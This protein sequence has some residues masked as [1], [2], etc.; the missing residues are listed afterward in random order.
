MVNIEIYAVKSRDW[1]LNS[2]TPIPPIYILIHPIA[3]AKRI[4]D[5]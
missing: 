1:I 5:S 4:L 3:L 2:P